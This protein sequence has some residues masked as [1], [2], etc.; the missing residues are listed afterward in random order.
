VATIAF[1]MGIDKSN[2]RFV[3]HMDLPKNIESYYQE[4]GRAGRDGLPSNALLFFSWADVQKLRRFATVDGNPQQTDVMLGKLDRI[5]NYGESK[6]CR[7]R[8]LLDYFGEDFS[9]T[10][11]HCDNCTTQHELFEGTI[12][13]QKALSAVYRTGQRFGAKYIVDLLCGSK[14]KTIRDE[15]RQLKTYGVGTEVSREAWFGHIKELIDQGLL[16]K[17]EG[18]YPVLKLTEASTDV[19]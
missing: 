2:V 16:Q 17:T 7:R 9:G 12:I 15:H 8:F 11:G 18:D 1:G 3:V 6:T 4:T 14:A 10:C 5:A 19:L 13:A